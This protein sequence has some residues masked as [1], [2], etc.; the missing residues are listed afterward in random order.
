VQFV[1][2]TGSGVLQLTAIDSFGNAAHSR[3]TVYADGV[4]IA[5]QYYGKCT[6]NELVDVPAKR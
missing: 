6:K 1:E 5:A 3:S 2:R 4:L